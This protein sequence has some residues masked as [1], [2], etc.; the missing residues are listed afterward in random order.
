MNLRG[1]FCDLFL[2]LFDGYTINHVKLQVRNN[3]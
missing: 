1:S 3:I 2:Y